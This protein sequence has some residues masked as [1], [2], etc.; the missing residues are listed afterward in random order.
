MMKLKH[1]FHGWNL[2][3]EKKFLRTPVG[4]FLLG[5]ALGELAPDP[6]DAI[7]FWLQEHVLNNPAV[8][9]STRAFL[10]VFDWYFMSSFY[11]FLLLIL[12]YSLH[13]R[14]VHTIKRIT[15]IGGLA[16]LGIV[17]GLLAQFLAS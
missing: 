9:A 17:I 7:H 13:I 15:I 6:T 11:F 4:V 14:R 5:A 2:E 16:A 12:A 3:P 1:L 10:Q 8:A